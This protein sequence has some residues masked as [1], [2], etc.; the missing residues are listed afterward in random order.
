MRRIGAG[1][2]DTGGGGG[3]PWAAASAEHP[4][5]GDRELPLRRALPRFAR[6]G[7]AWCRESTRRPR[8]GATRLV[9]RM[10][11]RRRD[12]ADVTGEGRP[13]REP[14][15]LTAL[16]ADGAGESAVLPWR[17]SR[18]ARPTGDD[19]AGVST[20]RLQTTVWSHRVRSR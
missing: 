19:E 10:P 18:T 8:L 2:F 16:F 5:E 12:R 17:R 3:P 11:L 14:R 6:D 13:A 9:E 20:T 4:A 7:V 15:P 1:F